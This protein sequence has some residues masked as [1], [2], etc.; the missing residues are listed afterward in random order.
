[1]A[2]FIFTIESEALGTQSRGYEIADADVP[3]IVAWASTVY[4][5]AAADGDPV[6]ISPTEALGAMVQG[7]VDGTLA[8]VVHWEREQ[9]LKNLVMPTP[10]AAVI[11]AAA[12]TEAETA[13]G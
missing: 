12:A 8:N 7:L 11:P 9:A 3:R 4:A 10:I 1:V 6:Q 13:A 2:K 5:P